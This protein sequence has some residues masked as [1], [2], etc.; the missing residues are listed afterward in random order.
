MNSF[1]RFLIATL[2]SI[3]IAGAV[4]AAN[5]TITDTDPSG[6]IT[7]IWADFEQGLTVNG[8]YYPFAGYGY[9]QAVTITAAGTP[10]LTFSGGWHSRGGVGSNATLYFVD[11]GTNHVRDLLT[12]TATGPGSQ[13]GL[14]SISG[15]FSS[16]IPNDLGTV[17]PGGTAIQIN[18]MPQELVNNPLTVPANL[19][20]QVVGTI[21]PSGN[22]T[23]YTLALAAKTGD[24]IGGET[25][26]ILSNPAINN[27]G[28]VAFAG[29]FSGGS[30]IFT[31][32]NALAKTGDT[33]GGI[34]LDVVSAPA[35]NNSGAIAFRAGFSG[36][37]GIFTPAGVLVKT[38]DTIGGKMLIAVDNP[39]INNRGA[40]VFAGTF[41]LV[42]SGRAIF[43]PSGVLVKSGDTIGGV[44]LIDIGAPAMNDAGTVAFFGTFSGG[45]GIFTPGRVLVKTGDTI[46]GKT[47]TGFDTSQLAINNRGTIAFTG[48][49]SGATGIFTESS[50]VVKSGDIIDGITLTRV[51]I[52]A[53]NNGGTIAFRAN[54]TGGKGIFTP[55]GVVVKVGDEIQGK[56][57]IDVRGSH[58]IDD[59]G[60][61]AFSGL[62]SDGTQ[63]LILAVPRGRP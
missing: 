35:I 14:A 23:G 7:I 11:A 61:V 37:T 44:D 45:T 33:I 38:G 28:T 58:A 3:F 16:D 55:S 13:F 36:G 30:G 52:P 50:V 62:L 25:L 6:K 41:Y 1:H 46:G 17:P 63:A 4:H 22:T 21:E 47:L 5:L 2:A 57:L 49:Y 53:I 19:T 51:G 54:F 43:T 24:I 20:F 56:I 48:Q 34:K 10:A 12:V 60:T 8:R 9:E 31:P 32:S 26:S 29:T 40:L 39:V 27:K 18:G 15:T 59:R 42:Y